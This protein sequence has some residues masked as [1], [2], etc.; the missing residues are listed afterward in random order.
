[1]DFELLK[2]LR[3]LASS[4][5]GVVELVAKT[6]AALSPNQDRLIGVLSTLRAA[7]GIEL[8]DLQQL[9]EWKH[10]GGVR[11]NDEEINKI[12][13]PLIDAHE[14]IWKSCIGPVNA[15]TRAEMDD[16][17]TK[18]T[19]YHPDGRIERHPESSGDV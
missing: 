6:E 18:K 15:V 3:D 14:S 5:V 13:K 1:M 7:F 10:F 12:F 9:E 11:Y 2:T 8:K 16:N 17:T 4:G 19:T